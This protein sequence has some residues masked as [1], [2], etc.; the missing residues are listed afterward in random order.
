MICG[1]LARISED[2]KYLMC[3]LPVYM[4]IGGEKYVLS[5]I[6]YRIHCEADGLLKMVFCSKCLH[7]YVPVVNSKVWSE[8]DKLFVECSGCNTKTECK[9]GQDE[10]V[11]KACT[12]DYSETE[13]FDSFFV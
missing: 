12:D 7:V 6:R 1:S 8:E 9:I 4:D 2:L 11:M 13:T 5:K 3:I 10:Y